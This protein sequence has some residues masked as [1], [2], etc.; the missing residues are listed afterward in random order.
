VWH[1]QQGISSPGEKK[2]MLFLS[3]F[4][5]SPNKQKTEPQPETNSSTS[6]TPNAWKASLHYAT[7]PHQLGSKLLL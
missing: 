3:V 7:F 1:S 5:F 6:W 2:P 4:F